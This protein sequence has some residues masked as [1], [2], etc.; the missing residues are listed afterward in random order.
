MTDPTILALQATGGFVVGSLIGYAAR[1]LAQWILLAIGFAL[2]P[3]AGLWYLGI[4]S[5]NWAGLN[6]LIGK[7]VAWLGMNLSSASTAL[8]SA[9]TFGIA[10]VAGFLF[11]FSGGF[12]HSV[13]GE[14]KF[15]K[16]R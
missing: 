12:R 9:G 2:L 7:A 8:A 11:G 15:V 3:I 6:A 13:F 4:I 5:V 14:K 10:S 16:K 1:K